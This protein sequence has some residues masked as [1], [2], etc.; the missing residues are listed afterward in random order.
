MKRNAYQE[1]LTDPLD[2]NDAEKLQLKYSRNLWNIKEKSK[3]IREEEV[4]V[5]AGVDVTYYQKEGKEWGVACAAFWDINKNKL[6]ETSFA[7][8]NITIPYKPGFLG[9]REGK[10]I[11]HAIQNAKLKPDILMCD[12]HGIIHPRFFGE[13][14]QLGLALNIPSF[15]VAKNPFIGF[16]TWQSLER[17]KG[18]KTP[19]WLNDPNVHRLN[20]RK[21]G[22]AVCLADRKKP[23]FISIG[24]NISLDTALE[25]SLKTTLSNRQPEPLYLAD[26]FARIHKI[27]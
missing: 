23:V 13:A 25:I 15:G 26:K 16:S 20:N 24:F 7:E 6:I 3:Q 5:I 19:I 27:E 14:V 10:I 17:V 11:S 22:Y 4:K 2:F 9:F 12:G 1:L 18:K 8:M 21:L